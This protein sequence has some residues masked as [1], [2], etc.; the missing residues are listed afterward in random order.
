MLGGNLTFAVEHA[1]TC[2]DLERCA[3]EVEGGYLDRALAR[4]RLGFLIQ[5]DTVPGTDWCG[6]V[7]TG[8]GV[9][10]GHRYAASALL[11]YLDLCSPPADKPDAPVS[12]P[13]AGPAAEA[14]PDSLVSAASSFGAGA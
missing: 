2:V 10:V 5:Y 9:G 4:M 12:P 7:V 14:A 3:P 1:Q 8:H 11:D 6:W 13:M